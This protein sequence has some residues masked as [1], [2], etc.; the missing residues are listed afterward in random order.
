MNSSLRRRTSSIGLAAVAAALLMVLLV[1]TVSA[2][3]ATP[4]GY[5]G[6]CNYPQAGITSTVPYGCGRMGGWDDGWM[7]GMMGWP[8]YGFNPQTNVT[9]TYPY[10]YGMM[11]GWNLGGMMGGWPGYGATPQ[12]GFTNTM[13]YGSYPNMMGGWG[14]SMMDGWGHGMMG[15]GRGQRSN[16]QSAPAQPAVPTPSNSNVSFSDYVQPIFAAR[17]VSCHGGTSGLYLNS[18]ENV[19]RG[20]AHGA[21]I[22]PGDPNNSR[23]IQY[24]GGGYMPFRNQPLTSAQIQTLVDWVAAGAPNN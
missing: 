5:W 18:Y 3:G 24:V 17:C 12:N 10:G 20:G 19:M 13:P 7:G 22:V 2:Q 6:N 1:S 9:G 15:G 11:G 23:L 21:V 4:Q 16:P 8:G 14:H